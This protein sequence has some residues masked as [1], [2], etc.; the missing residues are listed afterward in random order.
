MRSPE[1]HTRILAM[2]PPMKSLSIKK[3]TTLL[4]LLTLMSC[5]SVYYGAMEKIGFHKRDILSSRVEKARDSQQEAKE[6]FKSALE[7]FSEVVQFNGGELEEKYL[8]LNSEYTKSEARAE[9]VSSR[10]RAVETVGQDLFEEWEEELSTFS[11]VR[12][13]QASEKKLR[14]TSIRFNKLLATMKKAE[15]KIAPVLSAFRDQVLFL[16]HNL[17]ARAITALQEES[18]QIKSDVARLVAEME[19]S[20]LEADRFISSFSETS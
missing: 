5:S 4:S 7:K 16:K 12:L 13:K 11:N 2:V 18:L 1:E 8:E 15:A 6:Q 14:T 17:N 20:I 19:K 10:I 3:L 9:D